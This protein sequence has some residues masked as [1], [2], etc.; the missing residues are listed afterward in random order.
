MFSRPRTRNSRTRH[1]VVPPSSLRIVTIQRNRKIKLFFYLLSSGWLFC[2]FLLP[3]PRRTQNVSFLWS[4]D[5]INRRRNQSYSDDES[6]IQW[7]VCHFVTNDETCA[8]KWG[9]AYVCTTTNVN[10]NHRRPRK[11]ENLRKKVF[12]IARASSYVNGI[13]SHHGHLEAEWNHKT[14]FLGSC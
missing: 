2:I 1:I 8:Q 6:P 3:A 13:S 14:V 7:I 10:F 5:W 12:S 11:S 9:K 4:D